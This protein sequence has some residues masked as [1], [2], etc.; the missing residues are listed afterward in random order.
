MAHMTPGPRLSAI[1]AYMGRLSYPLYMIHY[2]FVSFFN[3]MISHF[4]VHGF[5]LVALVCLQM[6]A[7]V[8]AA[9]ASL[10]LFDEPMR[11]WLSQR[12]LRP[13]SDLA[14]EST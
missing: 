2:P 1:C 4:H 14:Q 9:I 12:M 11:A 8:A 10:H 13:R 6:S 7:A 3:K 5:Q